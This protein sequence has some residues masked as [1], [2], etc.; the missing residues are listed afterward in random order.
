[1]EFWWD[2][3]FLIVFK[4]IRKGWAL[5]MGDY[6]SPRKD[7]STL[8]ETLKSAEATDANSDVDMHDA[9]APLPDR[10]TSSD[11]PLGSAAADS[12]DKPTVAA[13]LGPPIVVPSGKK[14]LPAAPL[15]GEASVVGAVVTGRR[16]HTKSAA[17]RAAVA[18]TQAERSKA[19]NTL[20]AVGRMLCKK[21]PSGELG[22]GR[23][24]D[25]TI[26]ARTRDALEAFALGFGDCGPLHRLGALGVH[27]DL[28]GLRQQWCRLPPPQAVWVHGR[29]QQ[30]R[31]GQAWRR[32]AC[33][34]LPA[35]QDGR[36]LAARV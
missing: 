21:R 23:A 8:L 18:A 25:G 6:L 28:E 1:M 34:G 3:A 20:H 31:H 35:A 29:F 10:A 14:V 9:E 5:N 22:H 32:L 13:D 12:A 4:A 33:A 24:C 26:P 17:T 27:V 36:V 7:L 15:E 2:Y 16:V 11:D 19:G 30:D